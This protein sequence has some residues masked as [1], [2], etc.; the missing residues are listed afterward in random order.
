MSEQHMH[1]VPVEARESIVS[2][3]AGVTDHCES[4]KGVLG[5]EYG[6]VVK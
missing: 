6:F 5:M 2:P 4:P 3:M 1:T